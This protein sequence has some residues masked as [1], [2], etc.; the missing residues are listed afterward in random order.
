MSGVME[1]TLA[2]L[3]LLAGNPDGLPVSTIAEG[4]D[5]P[6]SAAHRLLKE[7]SKFGYVRQIRS[8]GDYAL[9][10]RLASL[11]LSFLGKTGVT[12]IAQPTLDRL[13]SISRELVRLSVVDYPNLVWVGVA[14]GA[15]GGLRYDPGRDQGT[16]VHLASSA[17]GM[18]WLSTLSD[19]EAL[20][21]VAAQGL[22]PP[23][24]AGPQVP[25]SVSEVMARIEE[26]RK[27]GYSI[28][29]DSYHAGMAAMAVPVRRS[30]DG[31]PVGCL[32]IAGPSIRLS[33]TRMEELFEPLQEAASEIG[34]ASEASFFF[35]LSRSGPG[36]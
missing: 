35:N 11:G 26:A 14:Q 3:E 30:S 9:T 33:T 29:V 27:R 4:L 17:G 6:A 7:L 10:I 8:Q 2:I 24:D 13:A 36:K 23:A 15:T 20:R 5:I 21:L 22:T 25:R 34:G 12:D 18:A 16:I 32:S 31:N 1:R 28:A 19:D